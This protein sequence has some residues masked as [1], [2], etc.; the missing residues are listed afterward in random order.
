MPSMLY[1]EGWTGRTNDSFFA[2]LAVIQDECGKVPLINNNLVRMGDP[3]DQNYV[4]AHKVKKLERKVAS[5][6]QSGEGATLHLKNE[7]AGC[8]GRTYK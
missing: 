7:R 5:A 6:R 2:E 3:M 8:S 1:W 4:L